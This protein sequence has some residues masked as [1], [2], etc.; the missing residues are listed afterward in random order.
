MSLL[1]S[2]VAQT[3]EREITLVKQIQGALGKYSQDLEIQSAKENAPVLGSLVFVDSKDLDIDR[4]GRSVILI[5][6]EKKA[7]LDV[8][9]VWDNGFDG[10]LLYPFRSLEVLSKVKL[11]EQLA[12]WNDVHAL[13]LGFREILES[14]SEDL[15]LVE[16]MQKAHLPIR[17][18]DIKNFNVRC[19]YFAG[20]RSGGDHFELSESKDQQ[21]VS[22]LLSDSSSYGL[23]SAILGSFMKIALNLSKD[24]LR[25]STETVHLIHQ[26]IKLALK[27]R[28]ELSLFYGIINRKNL[29]FSYVHGGNIEFF[30]ANV[31]KGFERL[32]GK[33]DQIT[34][35]TNPQKSIHEQNITLNPGDRLVVL[36]DGFVELVGGVKGALEILNEHRSKEPEDTLNEFGFILKK[37][38]KK[39]RKIQNDD[40]LLPKQDSTALIID[41]DGR[42]LRLAH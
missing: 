2:V 31:G 17:F 10:V 30:R 24:E 12:L 14:L 36:S 32:E 11:H 28:D 38:L 15:Y 42:V 35:K 6:D 4:Q 5:V 16:R 39:D 25:S 19:R 7:D 21:R 8:S 20:M 34:A 22:I 27:E 41:V 37:N 1:V 33:S 9:Q 23:S 29:Q 13:N 3:A 18:P 40:D 26:E